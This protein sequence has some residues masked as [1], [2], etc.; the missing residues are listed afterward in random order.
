MVAYMCSAVN[1]LAV[2]S[3]AKLW[4]NG[5]AVV[6]HHARFEGD[7]TSGRWVV[8]ASYRERHPYQQRIGLSM[9]FEDGSTAHGRVR[10]AEI[11]DDVV[12]FEGELLE[13]TA[14]RQM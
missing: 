8:R 10:V 2:K 9:E 7:P 11:G 13:E 3:I 5:E 12:V 1:P 4:V 14:W 6:V